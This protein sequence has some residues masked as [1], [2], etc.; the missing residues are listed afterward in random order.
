M[1]KRRAAAWAAVCATSEQLAG[2]NLFLHE[3]GSCSWAFPACLAALRLR[4]ACGNRAG[5]GEFGNWKL[6][7]ERGRVGKDRSRPWSGTQDMQDCEDLLER[8]KGRLKQCVLVWVNQ[9]RQTEGDQRTGKLIILQNHFQPWQ[10]QTLLLLC[11]WQKAW[12]TTWLPCPPW[13]PLPQ[14]SAAAWSPLQGE[15]WA[16]ES[17]PPLDCLC[18]LFPVPM[19][20]KSWSLRLFLG[21]N[22]CSYPECGCLLQWE[23]SSTEDISPL[24]LWSAWGN[25]VPTLFLEV[26]MRVQYFPYH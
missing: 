12:T 2:G 3:K 22:M 15:Q 21:R 25:K 16:T 4:L 10:G 5:V 9:C 18:C 11:V 24:P 6:S 1:Q 17:L 14:A 20:G 23:F 19:W 7:R 13:H 26:F 8:E